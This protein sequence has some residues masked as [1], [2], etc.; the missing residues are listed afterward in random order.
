MAAGGTDAISGSD[1]LPLVDESLLNDLKTVGTPLMK[2]SDSE[3]QGDIFSYMA[4]F[5]QF[6]QTMRNIN[7]EMS[8]ANTDA[9]VNAINAGADKQISAANERLSAAK[10]KSIA[11]GIGAGIQIGVG[12]LSMASAVKSTRTSIKGINAESAATLKAN[13][14][15]LSNNITPPKG[16][17]GHAHNFSQKTIISNEFAAAKKLT[18]QGTGLVAKTHALGGIGQ[19]LS[20][21]SSAI[22]GSIA[23]DAEFRGNIDDAEKTKLDATAKTAETNYQQAREV[24]QQMQD[25][26]RDIREKF[27]SIQQGQIDTNK[28]IVR[29]V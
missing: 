9:Q 15:E 20:Q 5:A 17:A 21:A 8:N 2:F 28:A 22:G 12:V 24:M 23:A 16:I 13:K 7:R 6:A 4:I 3:L 18:A 25:I 27:Q 1:S 29:N 19:G 11:E 26:L 10:T 14:L